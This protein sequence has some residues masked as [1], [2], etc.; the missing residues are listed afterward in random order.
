[1]T[2]G[3]GQRWTVAASTTLFAY[4]L[5]V[6]EL[7]DVTVYVERIQALFAGQ[8]LQAVRVKSPFVVRSYEPPISAVAGRTLSTT[9]SVGK[10]I[11]LQFEPELYVVVHLMI[12]G[13]FHLKQRS[14]ALTKLGLLS[15]DF[16]GQSMWLTEASSK[17]RAS[18]HVVATRAEVMAMSRGGV[19][20]L[21]CGFEAFHAALAAENHTLKRTL[22]DPRLISGI[23]NAYSDEI[24][25]RAQISPMKRTRDLSEDEARR[26]FDATQSTLSEWVER[27]RDDV[28]EGFPEKVTAFR[29]EMAVH[30]K[31]KQACPV[32][33]TPVQRI[34]YAE[35]ECNYCPRCQTAGRLLAD[36]ALSRLL[37]EDWPK[38]LEELEERKSGR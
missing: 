29:P 35:N 26:V 37:R 16:E 33:Q 18:V 32:C 2:A 23:G 31:Y 22:T 8:R 3:N 38:T 11:A 6:P 9:F 13:R 36:R 5:V 12:A 21:T 28:G 34:A 4:A 27:L 20:P 10:R 17:K 15:F 14:A 7:P 25:F 24:L 19:E 30:G 1:M